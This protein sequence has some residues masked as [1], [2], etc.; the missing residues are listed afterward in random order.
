MSIDVSSGFN[1]KNTLLVVGL[2]ALVFSASV[3]GGTVTASDEEYKILI[4]ALL[5]GLIGALFIFKN[6]TLGFT[7]IFFLIPLGPFTRVIGGERAI[8]FALG[9][10]LL[11]I[12]ATRVL[13][14]HEKIK[15]DRISLLAIALI[16]W[17]GITSLWASNPAASINFA[18]RVGQMVGLYI[19][20]LN[21]CRSP[22]QLNILTLSF[23]AGAL[24]AAAASVFK[25]VDTG[26]IKESGRITFA[27]SGYDPNY[28]SSVISLAL[29]MMF[30]YFYKAKPIL[31]K[32]LIVLGAMIIAYTIIR[33]Q[34]RTVWIAVPA[35]FMITTLL[36]HRNSRIVNYAAKASVILLL[37]LASA[38][39]SGIVN[40]SIIERFETLSN[41]FSTD[42]EDKATGRWEI[43]GTGLEM[44]KANPLFGVGLGNF[45]SVYQDY[46][47]YGLS[48]HGAHNNFIVVFAEM[49]LVGLVIFCSIFIYVFKTML[50]IKD[51]VT[52]FVFMCLF[53]CLTIE[54]LALITYAL[55]WFWFVM[56]IIA[57]RGKFEK[58]FDRLTESKDYSY[59]ST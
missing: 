31:L 48:T 58:Q 39:Y 22:R 6:P 25:G 46:A 9:T 32:A 26:V 43:W 12:Y 7:L 54:G 47:S 40:E 28:F 29:I 51:Q 38:Y 50:N 57:L 42:S 59:T 17:G 11:G 23:I 56:V 30:Y 49:G 55:P 21:Y 19:L 45:K 20:V 37:A 15:L 36:L 41:T 44:I 27:K 1:R 10:L 5:V 34:S 18:V 35:S 2:A 14:L 33:A 3:I 4:P 13:I 52:C 53:L 16:A 24:L 8:T